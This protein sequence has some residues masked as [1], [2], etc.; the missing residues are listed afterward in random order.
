MKQLRD[1]NL[2]R[3]K[4]LLDQIQRQQDLIAKNVK[5]SAQQ[6]KHQNQI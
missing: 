2:Q 5:L 1:A 6:L 4:V 3:E